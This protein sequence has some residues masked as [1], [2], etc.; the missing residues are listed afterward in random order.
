MN[1]YG[2]AA[3]IGSVGTTVAKSHDRSGFF[4]LMGT[5]SNGEYYSTFGNDVYRSSSV[6]VSSITGASTA[7]TIGQWVHI[8]YTFSANEAKIY[9]NGT[10]KNS[11]T[12]PINFSIANTQNLY[13]GKYSDSWYPLNGALDEV[14]LYNQTLSLNRISEIYSG[15]TPPVTPPVTTSA[16]KTISASVTRE[17]KPIIL[18]AVSSTN[19]TPSNLYKPVVDI[20]T[21]NSWIAL[22]NQNRVGYQLTGDGTTLNNGQKLESASLNSTE[23]K[24]SKFVDEYIVEWGV[25]EVFSNA[26]SV[27]VSKMMKFLVENDFTKKKDIVKFLTSKKLSEKIRSEIFKESVAVKINEMGTGVVI[28]FFANIIKEE[29]KSFAGVASR[30]TM[31][32]AL[33][34]WE[35]DQAFLLAQVAV[36]GGSPAAFFLAEANQT[37]DYVADLFDEAVKVRTQNTEQVTNVANVLNGL[38]NLLYNAQLPEKSLSQETVNLVKRT[39]ESTLSVVNNEILPEMKFGFTGIYFNNKSMSGSVI[40]SVSD[41]LMLA[42]SYLLKGDTIRSAQLVR[43][44]QETAFRK[45]DGDGG[46][47]PVQLVRQLIKEMGLLKVETQLRQG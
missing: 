8:A 34:A 19:I 44:V 26:Q 28:S 36:T 35:I 15:A 47:L 4:S 10:L 3:T 32:E 14:R 38:S 39:I 43:A 5:G 11:V 25:K 9:I 13:F 7:S 22:N 27:A 31:W 40:A 20:E 23:M 33:G 21:L 18:A 45:G 42:K 1:G 12:R 41:D 24:N 16:P 29:F 46:S 6:G 37:A 30:S 2:G 17:E